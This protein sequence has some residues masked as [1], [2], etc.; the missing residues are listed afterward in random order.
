MNPSADP[1]TE[2]GGIDISA[3]FP[4]NDAFML[5]TSNENIHHTIATMNAGDTPFAFVIPSGYVKWA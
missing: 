2:V 3:L 4:T 1:T 5:G